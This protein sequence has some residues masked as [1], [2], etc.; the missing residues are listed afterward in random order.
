MNATIH[1]IGFA[2][3]KRAKYG[4]VRTVVG[5]LSFASKREANRFAELKLME[6]AGLVRDLQVQHRFKLEVNGQLI[7]SYVADF[8]YRD[9]SDRLVTED[10]KG[11]ETDIFKLKRKLMRAVLGIDVVT[12]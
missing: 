3:R 8:T 10:A 11:V 6:R 5:G 4:N 7:C 9:P 12:V 1:P 2:A